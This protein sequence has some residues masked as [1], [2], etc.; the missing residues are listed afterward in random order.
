MLWLN[1]EDGVGRCVAGLLKEKKDQP[2]VPDDNGFYFVTK[3]FGETKHNNTPKQ[4]Q[5]V[6]S[7][8]GKRPG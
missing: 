1:N 2:D 4:Q 8:K 3:H 7:R 6:E 5:N